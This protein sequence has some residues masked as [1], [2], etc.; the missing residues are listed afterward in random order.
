MALGVILNE[1]AVRNGCNGCNGRVASVRDK[2]HVSG[3]A[4]VRKGKLLHAREEA[5]SVRGAR[6][7]GGMGGSS[8]EAGIGEQ[9]LLV[10][11]VVQG[12]APLDM[13]IEVS[14]GVDC[15]TAC[16]HGSWSGMVLM[17]IAS[18]AL[19]SGHNFS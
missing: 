8:G 7:K 1:E 9:Y 12:T 10:Q 14:G 3:R 15:D 6:A 4:Q 13:P 17:I 5:R 16:R 11:S 19:S 2:R 18:V